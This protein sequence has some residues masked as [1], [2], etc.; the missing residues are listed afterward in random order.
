MEN[1]HRY[2]DTVHGCDVSL[3]FPSV[4]LRPIAPFL[5]N[6]P[7]VLMLHAAGNRLVTGSSCCSTAAVHLPASRKIV[8][9]NYGEPL[10]DSPTASWRHGAA[11]LM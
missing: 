8:Y 11:L 9:R 1:V 10:Y 2:P 4:D 5:E 6:G 3:R 7:K